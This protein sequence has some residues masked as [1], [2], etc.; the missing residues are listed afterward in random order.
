MQYKGGRLQNILYIPS[1]IY[2][3]FFPESIV[4]HDD[5]KSNDW[6]SDFRRLADEFRPVARVID[7]LKS[8]PKE[9]TKYFEDFLDY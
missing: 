5:T 3:R 2:L 9:K 4:S 1:W 6:K 8:L 7:R